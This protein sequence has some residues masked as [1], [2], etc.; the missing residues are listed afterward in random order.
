MGSNPVEARF[1]PVFD[2][3]QQ[4]FVGY[5]CLPRRTLDDGKVVSDEMLLSQ[6]MDVKSVNTALVVE[7]MLG[8][9]RR[10]FAKALAQVNEGNGK[11]V[12][13]PINGAA[14]VRKEIATEF[15]A[16]CKT[17]PQEV[18]QAVVFEV[19]NVSDASAMSFLDE[20]AIVL[21][22]FCATYSCRISPLTQN[23]SFYATCNY[24]SVTLALGGQKLPVEKL[25]PHLQRVSQKAETSR[26]DVYLHGVP[27]TETKAAVE[28]SGI[29][30]MDGPGVTEDA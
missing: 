15:T 16:F 9:V 29:R 10:G 4:R 8:T 19:T 20:V 7:N 18:F 30:Y 23:Y 26:L 22:L 2:N 1:F 27:D 25:G 13:I 6:G 24:A 3:T 11:L 21:Y 12:I 5:Y 14:L 28:R 17:V